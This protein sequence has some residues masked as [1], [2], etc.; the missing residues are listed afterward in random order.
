MRKFG[1]RRGSRPSRSWADCS[2]SWVMTAVTATTSAR[3]VQLEM[4][5][6]MVN[7]TADPPEDLTLLRIV[8]DFSFAMSG[9]VTANWTLALV[10][11]DVT[12]TPSGLMTT[13]NDK[14]ILWQRS[15]QPGN[16]PGWT[17]TIWTTPATVVHTGTLSYAASS[18]GATHI[19]IAPKVKVEAGKAL[20]LVAYNNTS[21]GTVTT[22][23]YSMRVLF[24][25]TRRR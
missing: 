10:V 13:D 19:D 18:E 5:A 11:Q 21:T 8:G 24:Q 4:P 16:V 14:R 12:W 25:R 22:G 15:F 17:S 7:L 9:N 20:Y 3:L 1:N 2:A 6:S 23:S